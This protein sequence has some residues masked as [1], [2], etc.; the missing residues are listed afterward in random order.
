MQCW[1]SSINCNII[2]FSGFNIVVSWFFIRK[3]KYKFFF[4]TWY[5]VWLFVPLFGYNSSLLIS[6][7][8][9][10]G[11]CVRVLILIVRN[12]FS[13]VWAGDSL[14]P[15]QLSPLSFIYFILHFSPFPSSA[16]HL[17]PPP[18]NTSFFPFQFH[19]LSCLL[20]LCPSRYLCALLKIIQW[21]LG[22]ISTLSSFS[23]ARDSA[24][25]QAQN[26][27]ETAS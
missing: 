7:W 14:F 12:F 8:P 25:T 18:P 9:L 23:W 2:S 21:C 17:F 4:F 22:N 13:T 3:M 16:S 27:E 1:I 5:I 26:K 19:C 6:F 15:L 24:L 10:L 11:A 20:F